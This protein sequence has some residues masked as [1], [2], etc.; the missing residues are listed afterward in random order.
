MSVGSRA[1]CIAVQHLVLPPPSMNAIL[2]Y[3]GSGT[4]KICWSTFMSY[5]FLAD[6]V[7]AGTKSYEH[8]AWWPPVGFSSFREVGCVG[9]VSDWETA[10][11]SGFNFF[12]F[13]LES[14]LKCNFCLISNKQSEWGHILCLC[15]HPVYSTLSLTPTLPASLSLFVNLAGVGPNLICALTAKAKAKKAEPRQ[16]NSA[17]ERK[18]STTL[19]RRA[20]SGLNLRY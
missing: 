9:G 10:V 12:H 18:H 14:L 3:A 4:L 8:S 2:Q 17:R 13:T 19:C 20:L 5:S 1:A 15:L 6:V 16:K 7:V 11:S